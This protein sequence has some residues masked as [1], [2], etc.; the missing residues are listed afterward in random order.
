[1]FGGHSSKGDLN[2][3]E[4]YN[5]TTG[6][7]TVEPET[8]PA[9]DA[10]LAAVEGLNGNVY[11][12]GGRDAKTFHATAWAAVPPAA[13]SHSVFFFLHGFDEPLVNGNPPMDGQ[14][15]LNGSGLQLAIVGSANWA[16]FPAITGTI[17]PGGTVTV[18]IPSTLALGVINGATLYAT[19]LNGGSQTKLGSTSSLL[20]LRGTIKIPI[21]TPLTLKNQVL[22]LNLSTLLGVNIDLSQGR[23]FLEITGL[24]GVPTNP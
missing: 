23:I 24:N 13:P 6:H 2:S 21:S 5:F 14:F 8:L 4:G 7:W 11:L 3:V 10:F 9:P 17:E 22:V 19:D 15:P 18:T 20:G 1:V 12:L 16:S